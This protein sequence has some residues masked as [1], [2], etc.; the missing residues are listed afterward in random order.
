MRRFLFG[1]AA[2]SALV[3]SPVAAQQAEWP[4][5]RPVRAI[6]A[7]PPGNGLDIA[8]RVI[9][10]VLRPSGINMLVENRVG[11]L[12]MIAM[13]A[14]LESP[15][16]GYTFAVI[17][18]VAAYILPYLHKTPPYD[19]SKDLVY[20]GDF[21]ASAS[22]VLGVSA[23]SPI[24]TFQ[25]YVKFAKEKPGSFYGAS[26]GS[27]YQISFEIMKERLGVDIVMAPFRGIDDAMLAV[28]RDEITI[29]AGSQVATQ[30]LQ[31]TM[32]AIAVNGNK[33]SPLLPNIPTLEELGVGAD[34][35]A[36]S[37]A[38]LAGPK[39]T[40][41]VAIDKLSAEMKKA[42]ETQEVRE[43][44]AKLNINPLWTSPEDL[45]KKVQANSQA[46]QPVI[47]RLGLD[48]M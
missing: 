46:F 15:P 45:T 42:V 43:A 11:G 22:N 2:V 35:F 6:M 19:P 44:F 16:D 47:K 34:I 18:D 23:K 37:A 13:Q 17:T 41:K 29:T 4:G 27:A 25:D 26:P 31:G 39:G 33:R 20:V 3:A 7:S 10:N 32:R 48:T 28:Q 40:P 24:M 9:A 12:G 8:L 36:P 21:L 1:L 38:G 14:V 5:N 30:T